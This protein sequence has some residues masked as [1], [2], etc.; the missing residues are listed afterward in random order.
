MQNNAKHFVL[1][2][3][4]LVSL[5]LTLSFLI[6]LLF[7]V[8]TILYPDAANSW[9]TDSANE[10]VRIG[11]AMVIVFFPTY[12]VLTRTVNKLRRTEGKEWQTYVTFTKWLIYLSL[13]VGGFVLLGDLVAVIMTYL[14]GEL[15]QRFMLKAATV[16]VVVGAAFYYYVLDA[17]GFWLKHEDKSWMFAAGAL[18]IVLAALGFGFSTVESPTKVREQRLDMTQVSDLQQIQYRIQDYAVINKKLPT[19]LSDLS[20]PAVPTAP[21]TRAAYE[22]NITKNGFELC[23]TFAADS[24]GDMYYGGSAPVMEKSYIRNPDN[25]QHGTGKHC[26]DRTI[27]PDSTDTTPTKDAIMAQ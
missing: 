12:L 4:S 20:E 9:E 24:K 2:L 17:R 8:I 5:Y 27:N 16:L 1:Q 15:T 22:Y 21:E 10:Q 7:G 19:S 18:V 3:G 26:F 11:I 6:T 25:W 23:A 14:D 13:L